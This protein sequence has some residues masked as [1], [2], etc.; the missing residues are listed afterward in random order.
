MSKIKTKI[1][2]DATMQRI[3]EL[4][5][6]VQDDTPKNDRYLIE[7]D[8]LTSLIEEYEEEYYP[9]APPSLIEVI[10][11]RMLEMGLT[12]A[13]LST[14]LNVSPSRISDYLNGRC[15]PTLAIAREISKKLNIDASIVLGV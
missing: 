7:L 10:K 13:K 12:Q 5:P 6:L 15:E 4:C 8:L 9:I 2:Y 3:E 11:L 14:L 1:E